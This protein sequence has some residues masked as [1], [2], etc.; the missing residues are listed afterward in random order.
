MDHL[1]P[2]PNGSQSVRIQREVH[3]KGM[4]VSGLIKRHQFVNMTDFVSLTSNNQDAFYKISTREGIRS[5]WSGLSPTLVLAVPATILY[6]VSYEEVRLRSKDYYLTLFPGETD[7]HFAIPLLS[8]M[9]ARV[10][11]VT[12]FSPLELIRTKMQSQKLSYYGE[13]RANQF[14]WNSREYIHIS[15]LFLLQTLEKR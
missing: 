11:S 5:L 2:C 14:A 6:F 7:Q 9:A 3:Y 8:G 12:V 4:L 10:S 1:C 13:S 15:H